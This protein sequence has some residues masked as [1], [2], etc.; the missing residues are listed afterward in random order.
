MGLQ[1]KEIQEGG[2]DVFLNYI[3]NPSYGTDYFFN[4][5][6]GFDFDRSGWFGKVID[7]VPVISEAIH[8]SEWTHEEIANETPENNA[9][10]HHI[11]MFLMTDRY[12]HVVAQNIGLAN[13][14]RGLLIDDRKSGNMKNALLGKGNTAVEWSDIINNYKGGLLYEKWKNKK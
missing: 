13:E 10:E 4:Y 6:K 12:G 2:Y 1:S 3:N 7:N 5:S 8:I 11:G 14:L 9:L